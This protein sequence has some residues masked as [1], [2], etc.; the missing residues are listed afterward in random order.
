M[1]VVK[2]RVV[3]MRAVPPPSCSS[4]ESITATVTPAPVRVVVSTGGRLDGHRQS[5]TSARC[6]ARSATTSPPSSCRP[7]DWPHR[8]RAAAAAEHC[9]WPAPSVCRSRLQSRRGWHRTDDTG[10]RPRRRVR[11]WL[12]AAPLA[13]RWCRSRSGL[14]DASRTSSRRHDTSISRSARRTV[15]VLEPLGRMHSARARLDVI[16]LVGKADARQ[17]GPAVDHRAQRH[18]RR[19][20]AECATETLQHERRAAEP[21]RVATRRHAA[22][23]ADAYPW[24]HPDREADVDARREHPACCAASRAS[25]ARCPLTPA[26]LIGAHVG[27]DRHRHHVGVIPQLP[28]HA[29]RQAPRHGLDDAEVRGR[30]A[31]RWP[32][33]PAAAGVWR[34]ASA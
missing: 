7:C 17:R 3:L 13:T 11:P 25:P 18:P 23:L 27:V 4:P 6:V 14:V 2:S 30:R 24:R 32:A 20:S 1:P 19:L 26:T 34:P 33:V 22:A 28:Q 31:R 8:R 5:A 12:P 29:A 10:P 9:V 21:R 16:G 15:A